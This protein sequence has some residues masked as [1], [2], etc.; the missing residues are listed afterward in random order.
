MG[1]ESPE[2]DPY[3]LHFDDPGPTEP[4]ALDRW[5]RN[6]AS[7]ALVTAMAL[8]LQNVFDPEKVDTIAI[9]QEAPD[10]PFNPGQVELQF[11]PGDARGT[12]IVIRP[13][14]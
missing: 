14:S 9:E 3:E 1:G 11:D 4:G 2:E 6:T 7:G 10:E 8:G 13:P 12:R 5:R